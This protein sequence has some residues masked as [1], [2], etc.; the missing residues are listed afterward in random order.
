[1]QLLDGF[2]RAGYAP[3]RT[4]ILE[5]TELHERKSGAGIVS[6]LF[7]VASGDPA[8]ICLRPELTASIV[9]AFAAAPICPPLPWRLCR[10]G[11]VFRYEAEPRADRFKLREFTQVG[12]ELIGLG[13]PAADAEVIG[14][15]HRSLVQAG[16]AAATIRIGHVGLIVE[17]LGE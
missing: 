15:A 8:G 4:P 2:V 11:R 17:I 13:G 9:R 5:F 6:K 14:L 7:E 10:A 1:G 16:I 12:L 3:V